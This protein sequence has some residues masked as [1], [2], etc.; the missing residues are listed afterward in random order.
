M[1]AGL[2]LHGPGTEMSGNERREE[3]AIADLANL[4]AADSPGPGE[5]T[6]ASGW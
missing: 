1:H 3:R 4:T 6:I 2:L 5:I